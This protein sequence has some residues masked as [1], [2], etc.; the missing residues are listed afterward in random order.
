MNKGKLYGIGVGP[1]DPE[2]LTIKAAKTLGCSDIIAV[3]DKGTGKNIAMEIVKD[4]IRG[5]K[6]LYCHTPMVRDKKK[7]DLCYNKIADDISIFLREGKQVAF[8]TLGDPTV[9]STYMNIHRRV[10]ERGFDTEIIPGVTS[11]CA[12]AAKLGSSLCEGAERLLIVP[13]SHDVDDIM[14]VKANK[15]FMK[16]GSGVLKLREKLLEN[17]LQ[18]SMV[19][20][21]G[22]KDE[23][24]WPDIN[25]ADD[26][27]Y[28]AIVITKER[29][30]FI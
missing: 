12:A 19:V 11:F 25:A 8:I 10:T 18:S 17:N 29:T 6:L 21:C 28:F 22:M 27:G 4:Y 15:V 2:L 9:Y 7:L 20:N 5:K 26:L 14:N 30:D 1:G 16:A 13:A 3:P 23:H 24:I